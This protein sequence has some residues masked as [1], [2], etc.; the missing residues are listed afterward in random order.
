MDISK[1]SK[2]D[3]L[4][5]GG[6]VAFLIATFFPWFTFSVGGFS[7]SA[8]GWDYGFWGVLM[9]IVLVAAATL[10]VLPAA[11]KPV[12]TPAIVVLALTAM[13]T[14]FVLLKL[15]IG[16]DG[17]SRSFGII[18]AVL[19]AA[20]A[21]FGAFLKFQESGGSIEDLKDPNKLK[22][23]MQSGFSTL[24]QDIKEGAREMG[25][26]AKGMADDV[27]DKFDGDK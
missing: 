9:L 15:I 24:A 27:K 26:D 23:Q 6:A 16:Q 2:G 20:A 10:V 8:N 12:K 19:S 25:S 22:G 13:A 3:K 7:A 17:L 18:L 4:V 11:G 14:L 1:L 21:T 5:A